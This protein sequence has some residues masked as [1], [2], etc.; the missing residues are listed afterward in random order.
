MSSLCDGSGGLLNSSS[1]FC[2]SGGAWIKAAYNVS[3]GKTY[4]VAGVQGGGMGSQLMMYFPTV[5]PVQSVVSNV[6]IST[7]VGTKLIL[8]GTNKEGTNVLTVLDTATLQET[9]IFDAS[10]EVEVY[11]MAYVASTNKLMFNGLN[12]VDGSYVVGEVVLP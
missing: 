4:V 9:I 1:G 7:Q 12:F 2:S 10:N 8:A 5:E 3:G 11:N 6:T